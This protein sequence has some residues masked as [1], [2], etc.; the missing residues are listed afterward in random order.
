LLIGRT[1]TRLCVDALKAAVAEAKKGKDID[2]YTKA[3][4]HLYSISPTEQESVLEGAWVERIQQA[5]KAETQ[6]LEAELKGYKN[7]LIKESIR[8]SYQSPYSAQ[9]QASGI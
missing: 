2:R 3:V 5:N 1:S 9:I 8:V 7:N 4:E 6:R